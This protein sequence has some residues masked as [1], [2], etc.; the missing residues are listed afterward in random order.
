MRTN[1][2]TRFD[3]L[4]TSSGQKEDLGEDLIQTTELQG[5]QSD[6]KIQLIKIDSKR[7]TT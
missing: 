2:L 7:E 4:P 5:L 1:N 3:K 6:L